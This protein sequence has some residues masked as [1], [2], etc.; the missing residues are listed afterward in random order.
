MR[1]VCKRERSERRKGVKKE[2]EKRE[3]VRV[4]KGERKK[5]E[6]ER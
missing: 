2:G 6:S 3:V 4:G 1:K 5:V